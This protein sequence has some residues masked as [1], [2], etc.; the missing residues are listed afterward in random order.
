MRTQDFWAP[1]ITSEYEILNLCSC[2]DNNPLNMWKGY[3]SESIT[4]I[5]KFSDVSIEIDSR[6]SYPS[7][8]NNDAEGSII[9]IVRKDRI[10]VKTIKPES[11]WVSVLPNNILLIKTIKP[12]GDKSYRKVSL[13][14]VT[15][16]QILSINPDYKIKYNVRSG[17]GVSHIAV[18]HRMEG[19]YPVRGGDTELR[20]CPISNIITFVEIESRDF[21]EEN[22]NIIIPER[23]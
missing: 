22:I 9:H 23:S 17:D 15:N 2:E 18:L 8:V 19:T 6:I 3:N 21:K 11:Y 5:Y 1:N 10:L 13:A 4:C 20:M 7:Q 14:Q 12:L 16:S